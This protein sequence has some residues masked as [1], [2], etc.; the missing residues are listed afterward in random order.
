MYIYRVEAYVTINMNAVFANTRTFLCLNNI[1]GHF[2]PLFQIARI[3]VHALWLILQ[4]Y[5]LCL[6]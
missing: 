1:V 6:K 4:F 3:G 2:T 5:S